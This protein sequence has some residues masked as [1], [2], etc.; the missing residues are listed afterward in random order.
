MSKVM[1]A[2]QTDSS[3]SRST[4]S[5]SWLSKHDINKSACSSYDKEPF[6][7]DDTP[8]E[9]PLYNVDFKIASD[10]EIIDNDR[11]TNKVVEYWFPEERDRLN[12]VVA[13]FFNDA[14][15][16]YLPVADW[17]KDYEGI[18]THVVQKFVP[19]VVQW[20]AI[21]RGDNP[22]EALKRYEKG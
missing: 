1:E 18:R 22:A 3:Q 16:W 20:K 5:F 6:V 13:V 2:D 11:L 21:V 10:I 19:E 7:S 8:H 15:A 9:P 12:K 14:S 17:D 4:D